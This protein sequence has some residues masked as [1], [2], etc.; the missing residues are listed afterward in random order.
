MN[1]QVKTKN[2]LL[3]NFLVRNIFAT[4]NLDCAALIIV[5]YLISLK[6]LTVLPFVRRRAHGLDRFS[7]LI[8]EAAG[9]V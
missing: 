7:K 2:T 3:V 1:I 6:L 4:R 8:G 9:V 5:S